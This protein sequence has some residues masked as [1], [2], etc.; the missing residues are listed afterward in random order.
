MS[1]SNIFREWQDP[2]RTILEEYDQEFDKFNDVQTVERFIEEINYL[3]KKAIRD[4]RPCY[5]G[6]N[7]YDHAEIYPDDPKDE[8]IETR[9]KK[10]YDLWY[11][12]PHHYEISNEDKVRINGILKQNFTLSRFSEVIQKADEASQNWENAQV[13]LLQEY[14]DQPEL[15]LDQIL[16]EYLEHLDFT[17]DMEWGHSHIHPLKKIFVEKKCTIKLIRK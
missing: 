8:P 15:D 7:N 12:A 1:V 13:R 10:L 17:H 4:L 3:I 11:Q 2:E 5:P 16:V 6:T 9:F 14:A